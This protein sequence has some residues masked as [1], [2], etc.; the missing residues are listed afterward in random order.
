MINVAANAP[1]KSARPAPFGDKARGYIC[2][3][4]GQWGQTLGRGVVRLHSSPQGVNRQ[5][6]GG[7]RRSKLVRAFPLPQGGRGGGRFP[8]LF[9]ANRR[10]VW[11]FSAARVAVARQ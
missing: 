1:T 10:E 2:A 6:G 4:G 7:E 3:P 5:R 11:R 9:S 8:R